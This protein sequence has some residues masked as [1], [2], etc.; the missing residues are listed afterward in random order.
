LCKKES[1]LERVVAY[2]SKNLI[3]AQRKF[4]PM[5]GECYTLIRGIMHFREY[6]HR[7]HF[8]LKTNHKPLE[9]LMTM[10]DA[11]GTKGRWIDMFQHFSFKILHRLGLK[12]TNVD[13]LNR[14]PMGQAM[15]DDDFNE[16][17]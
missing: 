3:V 5:E 10:S 6:L 14:N 1:K 15:N 13:A 16:K 2:A 12:H 8:T 17:I 9:W 11:H 4:H 7:N